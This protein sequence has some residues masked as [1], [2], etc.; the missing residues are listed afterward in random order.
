M[1]AVSQ[2]YFN[3][4][5]F[6]PSAARA[7]FDETGVAVF[8]DLLDASTVTAYTDALRRL[9]VARLKSLGKMPANELDLDAC[10]QLL[11]AEDPSHLSDL[12]LIAREI[13]EQYDF[14]FAPGMMRA[15]SATMPNELVQLVPES[16]GIRMD[17]P[18]HDERGFHWHY[19]YSYITT[20]LDGV[21]GWAP[22]L[23]MNA[24]MGWL[25]VVLGSHKRIHPI[26]VHAPSASRGPFTGHHIF[27]LHDAD[28]AS[29]EKESVEIADV[30]PGDLVVLHC[31]LLHRS[32]HNR[33]KRARWTALCRFGNALDPS[34]VRRGWRSVRSKD[35]QRQFNE[36]HP[37]LVYED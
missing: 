4:T 31:C 34:V 29:L 17:S 16:C 33:G 23:P 10:G 24:Q 26:R 13:R 28:F 35:G 37:D 3:G 7:A 27:S 11:V 32:G 12:F 20:S 2:V 19:D 21:T 25:K 30:G 5:S 22:V 8:K 6:D 18:N 9:A 14:L 15:I 1:R 36:L